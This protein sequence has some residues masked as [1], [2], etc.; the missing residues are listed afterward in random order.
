MKFSRSL[1]NSV[2]QRLLAPLIHAAA[3]HPIEVIA[4]C[5][6]IASSCYLSLIDYFEYFVPHKVKLETTGGPL[7]LNHKRMSLSNGQFAVVDSSELLGVSQNLI[8]KQV[9]I[10]APSPYDL[11]TA[12]Q[13]ATLKEGQMR[14]S[15]H[16]SVGQ[17]PEIRGVLQKQVLRALARL[18]QAIAETTIVQGRTQYSIADFCYRP[19]EDAE[20]LVLS[21]LNAWNNDVAEL[22]VDRDILGTISNFLQSSNA[23]VHLSKAKLDI[24]SVWFYGLVQLPGS[25][26]VRGASSL[27][28][29][30]V[31]DISSPIKARLVQLWE[32]SL[33]NLHSSPAFITDDYE[34]S[35]PDNHGHTITYFITTAQLTVREFWQTTS[36][37]DMLVFAIGFLLMHATFAALFVSM[38]SLGSRFTLAFAVLC[39]GLAA[40]SVGLVIARKLDLSLNAVQLSEAIP[41]LVSVIGFDKPYLLTKLVLQSQDLL[42]SASAAADS[43]VL[44]V[45]L[46]IAVLL[47]GYVLNVPGLSSFCLLAA[48]LLACDFIFLYTFYLA[49]LTLKLE[50]Q[51][52]RRISGDSGG[53]QLRWTAV[54]GAANSA[55]TTSNLSTGSRIK[56]A[57]IVGLLLIHALHRGPLSLS[58]FGPNVAISNRQPL[59]TDGLLSIL[60]YAITGQSIEKP[61][62][63]VV[64]HVAAP[65]NYQ[66]VQ[67]RTSS[68]PFSSPVW[69]VVDQSLDLFL[70]V[71]AKSPT[72]HILVVGFTLL[73]YYV[74]SRFLLNYASASEV[75]KNATLADPPLTVPAESAKSVAPTSERS[76]QPLIRQDSKLTV[77]STHSKETNC[78]GE[79]STASIPSAAFGEKS[80]AEAVEMLRSGKLA[81]HALEKAFKHDLQSAVRIRRLYL[82]V[83]HEHLPFKDFAYEN[84][85]G[86]CCEN[87]IGYVP[88]PLGVAGPLLVNGEQVYVPMATTEG[89]LVASTSRGC[90]AISECGGAVTVL[91]RDGMARGPALS[92]PN[93]W[94]A[95]A[96]K[97]FLESADG[98]ADVKAAFDSTSRFARLQAIKAN[99]AGQYLFVRFVTQTGDAMGMNMISKGVEKALAHL[100]LEFSD[101]VVESIS[102]NFCTDKKPAALNWI[103]GRGKSVVSE[104]FIDPRV[105]EKVLKTTVD[106]LVHLNTTKN[107]VGSAMAGSVGGFNAHAANILTAV[108]LATGQDPAQNVESSNCLTLMEKTADGRLRI[109]CTMPCIEVGTVGGGTGL[110]AQ[111]RCLK[112]LGVAG[113]SI[114]SP[115]KNAQK[116]AQIIC[117]AVMAG[118]LSLCSALAAG[119]LVKSH[120]AHNRKAETRVR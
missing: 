23:T 42:H 24:K 101:M 11:E 97:S 100:S 83:D 104:A 94:R 76:K 53:S 50:L 49:I 107:L 58:S 64:L 67:Y 4:V 117:A 119:H 36:R 27:V 38:R 81:V 3:R 17:S 98:F 88:L 111:S 110:P 44:D 61:S 99:M 43:L 16:V 21:P 59:S 6:L 102:G 48:I 108:F 70:Q 72:L 92:F 5:L 89:C 46:E 66:T 19:S 68:A 22:E 69:E 74:A 1:G 14:K 26:R 112:M 45:L 31:L 118:E 113:A 52:V 63:S 62:P 12:H 91:V 18:Q 54:K 8:V 32:Q 10:D 65:L 85:M 2:A 13:L 40:L 57:V 109:T 9:I 106:A 28:I 95:A 96:C 77:V 75:A 35:S 47:T 116:L 103:D 115:G 56:L 87:V 34:S 78:M 114:S 39:S 93:I 7:D 73:L 80:D 79:V 29:S 20:C 33:L 84:V 71:S 86:V 41:F 105:V 120:M 82:S 51:R 55:N 30:Y 60:A 90:K 25:N 15:S 37:G